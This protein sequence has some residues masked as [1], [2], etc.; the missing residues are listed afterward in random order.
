VIDL[1]MTTYWKIRERLLGVRG[2]A[3]VAIWGERIKMPQVRVDPKRLAAFGVTVNDVLQN[4]SD[5]LDAGMMQY[6]NGSTIG[7]G[8]FLESPNQR[9]AIRHIQPIITP[10]D[11]ARIP[12][13]DHKKS[14]GT[15]VRLGDV[16]DV[17]VDTWPMI[18]DAVI[19]DGPGLLLIVEKFPW[20]NSLEVTNGVEAAIDE[21]RPGLPG[22]D[23]DTTIFRPATFIEVALENLN[24]SL[25]IGAG[26]VVLI[27]LLF[28]WDWRT[29]L[30]SVVAIP[31]SLVAAGLV[32]YLRGV[33]INTMVLAGF[34]IAVGVVVDDAI[35]DVENIVRRL[36]QARLSGSGESTASIVMSASLEVR[37]AIVYATLID[38]ITL[39]PVFF[40]QGLS[41]AF[42][43]PLA[44]SY[45]LAVLASLLVALTVT[46][47]MCLIILAKAP[48]ERHV[49][50]V[51]IW[52]QRGYNR[53]LTPIIRRPRRAYVTVAV[54][55]LLGLAVVPLL[56]QSL[57]P[58]FKERDFLMH[59]VTK[60][61]TS[62]PEM[63]RIS[64]AACKEL[65]TIP[66]VRN[67][68]THI[69]QALLM[70]EVYGIYFAEN[71]ISV[72]PSVNYDATLAKVQELVDGYPG[73]VRDVQTYLK[74]RIR[75]VLTGSSHPII[76]RI[77]GEDLEVLR[78]KAHEVE[79]KLRGIKGLTNLHV[80]LLTD[81][82]QVQIEVDLAKAK[83]YGLKPGD[84]RRAA[85][86]LVAGE[87][88][89]DL[90]T[91]NRTYDVN[92]WTQPESR[93]SLS[94]IQNL[95]ID[96]PSGEQVRLADVADVRIVA[97]PNAINREGQARRINVDADVEGRDLGSVVADVER[98]LQEIEFPQGYHPELIGEYAERQAAERSI[99]LTGLASMLLILAILRVG[100]GSWRLATM[101]FLG[102]PVALVGG[103][104]AA[105]FASDG[106]LSLG[107]LV[108]F[109]TILG[110]AA[111]NG[112]MLI[113]HYQHLE[114][115][116]G[117]AFG[118]ELVLR[119]ARE[120]VSP[121]L[122]TA[123][124][125]GLA[126]VPLVIAGNIPGHEIE[127]PMAIVIL[128]GLITSTLL[129]L[130]IVPALYLRFGEARDSVSRRTVGTPQT[131]MA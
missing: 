30:I 102:L 39:M 127:H 70:D 94:D 125:T 126:L 19:N 80:E 36:R 1:S 69:G 123:L 120:R 3:N 86:Y 101:S 45:G 14:D 59:W 54:I 97:T 95:L 60:P 73:L 27:L 9:L 68:G 85:A 111:R 31:L 11:L 121:I 65:R 72:D 46:P 117:E 38:V 23:I 53:L 103:V 71:W 62:H 55:A 96:T 4:T 43:Q 49:S 98:A 13:D 42:F 88:A 78:A 40:M 33:T 113:S 29:A 17:V 7:K 83:Q 16:A 50:P 99:L 56:G 35:I 47:A 41:G 93:D 131:S 66:G 108:G 12:I 58:S 100:L 77:Y 20:A 114:A 81:I 129:N 124:A 25:L 109:L 15:P 52:V 107:S 21:M 82:P 2:V 91:G 90:H 130:F 51:H 106:I 92:V 63:V 128:G 76:L 6:S 8:G 10:E 22:I 26:L 32:L 37:G 104:L 112:I 105:Y 115:E 61:G 119:G 84:V 122:M 67:C 110:I 18:G 116:E 48:I 79:E 74:E 44:L 118:P 34:V 24:R 87:E 5:T 57:L 89:G 75:E 64:T 28:L